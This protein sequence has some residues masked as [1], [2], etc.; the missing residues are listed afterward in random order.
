MVTEDAGG[1]KLR[2]WV[3]GHAR[4]LPQSQMRAMGL[5]GPFESF[6]PS[7]HHSYERQP[8]QQQP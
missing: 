4:S 5:T 1:V 8:Q 7:H 6:F 2:A 3:N